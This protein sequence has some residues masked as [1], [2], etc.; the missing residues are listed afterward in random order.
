MSN[1]RRPNSFAA[2]LVMAVLSLSACMKSATV[3]HPGAAN[4]FDSNT[5]DALV[6]VKASIDAA[7][8]LATTQGQKDIVNKVIASYVA[9]EAA[10]ET[11]HNAAVKGG[12]PDS[13][14]LAADLATLVKAAAGLATQITGVQ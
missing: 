5:Y 9:V 3:S 10:Y 12:V 6:S 8:P 14:Q 11:Y 13:T 7:K 2:V 1:F 4:Q